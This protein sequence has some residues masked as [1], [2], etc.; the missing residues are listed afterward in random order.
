MLTVKEIQT[1]ISNRI[2]ESMRK[3]Y[4]AHKLQKWQHQR[5]REGI[6]SLQRWIWK[7]DKVK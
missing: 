1:E 3:E 6:E 2:K 4:Q 7:Q 5:E